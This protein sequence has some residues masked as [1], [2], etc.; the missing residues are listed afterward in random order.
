M[1]LQGRGVTNYSVDQKSHPLSTETTEF[2]DALV[3]RGVVNY[4]QVYKAKGASDEQAQLLANEKR[5]SSKPIPPE[6][7]AS[8]PASTLPDSDEDSFVDDE[9][10]AF[11]DRY[12]AERLQQLQTGVI[13]ITRDQWSTHINEASQ[14]DK[15]ILVT[16]LNEHR[17]DQIVQELHHLSREDLPI[18]GWVTIDAQE[19]VPNWPSQR[20]PAMFAYRNGI[21]QNEWIAD[22]PGLLPQR[23]HIKALF[24]QWGILDKNC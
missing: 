18:A 10:D 6:N 2:D 19:A 1:S 23:D 13:H 8:V 11:F 7:I 15:W 12:R 24:Q 5:G 4:E 22:T 14:N 16:L 21:K 9:D 3:K 17:R 20:V